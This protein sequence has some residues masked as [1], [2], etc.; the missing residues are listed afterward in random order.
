MRCSED[1]VLAH[2]SAIRACLHVLGEAIG[3]GITN[4]VNE[5]VVKIPDAR[6]DDTI[7]ALLDSFDASVSAIL[8]DQMALIG[9]GFGDDSELNSWIA[10]A[11]HLRKQSDK[12]EVNIEDCMLMTGL[13]M[14]SVLALSEAVKVVTNIMDQKEKAEQAARD[15]YA[16]EAEMTAKMWRDSSK[17]WQQQAMDLSDRERRA[18]ELMEKKRRAEDAYKH[19]RHKWEKKVLSLGIH[20]IH[21]KVSTWQDSVKTILLEAVGAGDIWVAAVQETLHEELTK[22]MHAYEQER[23][24]TD[25]GQNLRA[26]NAEAA[27]LKDL[28]VPGKVNTATEKFIPGTM[29]L[30]APQRVYAFELARKQGSFVPWRENWLQWAGLQGHMGM[31]H[32]STYTDMTATATNCSA[33]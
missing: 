13:K 22:R 17:T 14:L 31:P 33:S 26:F 19:D 16:K 3:E 18:N 21:N 29:Q 2:V 25:S 4:K 1:D 9:S 28:S 32:T 5:Y 10:T 15:A 20:K 8:T 11:S 7:D 23:R 12:F 27:V 24:K 30:I 6:A